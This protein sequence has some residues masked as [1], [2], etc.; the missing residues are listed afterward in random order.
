[1]TSL[2]RTIT[3]EF[4]VTGWDQSLYDEPMDGPAMG[5]VTVRK[6]FRGAVDGTSVAEL[7][8]AG[9]DNGRGY[10]ASERFTGT[11]EG[12]KGTVVFLHGGLDDGASPFTFGHILPGSGTD[13]LTGLA[14]EVTYV[15]DE[16]GAQVT[17]VLR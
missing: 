9:N 8:T 11:V 2:T 1:M 6:T 17:L 3:G 15:H 16:S 13:E 7:L 5:R 4:E 12:R 14:G 10:V